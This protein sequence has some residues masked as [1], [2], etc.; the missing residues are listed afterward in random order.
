MTGRMHYCDCWSLVTRYAGD[1]CRWTA[2]IP[3]DEDR[4]GLSIREHMKEFSK[5]EK[6]GAFYMAPGIHVRCIPRH[7]RGAGKLRWPC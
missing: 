2:A 1:A 7:P 4:G 3:S 6:T 5:K